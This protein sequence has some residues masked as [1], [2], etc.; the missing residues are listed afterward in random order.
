MSKGKIYKKY[1]VL[2]H[3]ESDSMFVDLSENWWNGILNAAELDLLED[4]N[5]LEEANDYG[6]RESKIRG[7]SFEPSK[8]I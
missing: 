7:N 2:Q 1:I 5:T 3:S 4:F 8:D 6:E